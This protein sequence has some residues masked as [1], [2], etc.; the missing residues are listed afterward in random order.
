MAVRDFGDERLAP[1]APAARAGHVGF[2]P[3]LVDKNKA[4]WINPGLV[5]FPAE[6]APGNVG[7]VLLGGEQGFFK[8]DLLA[9]RKRHSVSQET[10]TPRSRSSPRRA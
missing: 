5:F 8:A 10:V 4:R 6:T 1:A 2:G 3:G 9:L 7:P